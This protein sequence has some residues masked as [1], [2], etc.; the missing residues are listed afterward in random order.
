MPQSIRFR[1]YKV[2]GF[3]VKVDSGWWNAWYLIEKDGEFVRKWSF[4]IPLRSSE[5][6]KWRPLSTVPG[7]SKNGLP[8]LEHSWVF[9]VDQLAGSN[10][11]ALAES[12]YSY[13]HLNQKGKSHDS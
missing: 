7:P 13:V 5:P 3:A 12:A 4:V 8:T 2:S 10:A 9:P 1:G 11:T 6:Q